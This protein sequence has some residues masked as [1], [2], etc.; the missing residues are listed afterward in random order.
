VN[1]NRQVG[2]HDN[3]CIEY[4]KIKKK[5]IPIEEFVQEVLAKKTQFLQ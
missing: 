3:F 1:K 4:L 5:K 2:D